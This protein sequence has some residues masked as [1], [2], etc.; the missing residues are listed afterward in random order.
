MSILD[1][2]TLITLY[3]ALQACLHPSTTCILR[4]RDGPR[5]GL[6][7]SRKVC[8]WA[9]VAQLNLT[10]CV[11]DDPLDAIKKSAFADSLSWIED[12]GASRLIGG[13]ENRLVSRYSCASLKGLISHT[14][15][16]TRFIQYSISPSL[17]LKV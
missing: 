2:P 17:T 9:V 1:T 15:T 5:S 7:G 8:L 10:V 3:T 14:L 4:S 12:E 11:T 16:R 6:L 13:K